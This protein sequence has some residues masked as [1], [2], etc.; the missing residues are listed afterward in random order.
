MYFPHT[1]TNKC[2]MGYQNSIFKNGLSLFSCA[3]KYTLQN[4][5]CALGPLVTLASYDAFRPL[6]LT[7]T[8]WWTQCGKDNRVGG[9]VD[10]KQD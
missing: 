8:D 5:H 2:S 9:L 1:G 10:R 7:K 3:E 6:L 4:A